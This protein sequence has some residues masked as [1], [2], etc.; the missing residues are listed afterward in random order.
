MNKNLGIGSLN[1]IPKLQKSEL[2]LKIWLY[3]IYRIF[4]AGITGFLHCN[5]RK[6]GFARVMMFEK[7]RKI[8]E[9]KPVAQSFVRFGKIFYLK[10][11]LK[12]FLALVMGFGFR[13][14]KNIY[15]IPVSG[16]FT[17]RYKSRGHVVILVTEKPN[18]LFQ[19]H[20]IA[21]LEVNYQSRFYLKAHAKRR[22]KPS[23]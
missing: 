7:P 21:R 14:G 1:L 5:Y 3:L 15:T 6:V 13:C 23:K 8:L 19:W 16:I 12:G 4:W 11:R 18:R 10:G 17:C 2:L 22:H 9:R 20:P